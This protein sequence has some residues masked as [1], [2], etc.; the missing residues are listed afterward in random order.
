[1]PAAAKKPSVPEGA[2][3]IE[4][5]PDNR[6]AQISEATQEPAVF[7]AGTGDG[8]KVFTFKPMADWSYMASR[9]F[10]VGDL[11]TWCRGALE[12]P[13]QTVDFVSMSNRF[14]GRVTQH[15][16]TLSGTTRGEGSSSSTS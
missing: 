3:R 14:V 5:L 7:V 15:F 1:M 6:A 8:Q 12:E 13:E 10:T 2:I 4:D 16:E 9:A 11:I